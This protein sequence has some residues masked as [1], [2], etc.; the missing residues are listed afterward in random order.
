MEVEGLEDEGFPA[1]FVQGIVLQTVQGGVVVE[2]L[3]F[4]D[5]ITGKQLI[6][7]QPISRFRPFLPSKARFTSWD[8]VQVRVCNAHC[9]FGRLSPATCNT[10]GQTACNQCQTCITALYHRATCNRIRS[11]R[12]FQSSTLGCYALRA[13]CMPGLL[14]HCLLLSTH[15]VD[16]CKRLAVPVTAAVLT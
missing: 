11:E 9:A 3:E 12:E 13:F 8:D 10:R 7:Y 14:R 15:P 4:L 2:Y 16:I 5:E 1:S 6:E